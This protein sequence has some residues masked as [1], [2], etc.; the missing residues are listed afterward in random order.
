M[1]SGVRVP[2]EFAVHTLRE[3]ILDNRHHITSASLFRRL[4][5]LNIGNYFH[6]RILRWAGHVA[7]MPM[8]RAPRQVLTGWISHS[9]PIGCPQMT[10]GRMLE[11]ALKSKGISKDFDE[12]IAIAKVR[13]S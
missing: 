8:S 2:S 4:G 13:S 9:R 11:N 5:I 6:N 12:W 3:F 1:G 10:W 7:R